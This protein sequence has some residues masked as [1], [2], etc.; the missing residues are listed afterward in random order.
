MVSYSCPQP[1]HLLLRE[2]KD[3]PDQT[4]S[5]RVRWEYW[6]LLR[7]ACSEVLVSM[8]VVAPLHIR[9]SIQMSMPDSGFVSRPTTCYFSI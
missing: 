8:T 5:A 2:R 6:L 1:L 7:V 4:A 9:Q 3:L